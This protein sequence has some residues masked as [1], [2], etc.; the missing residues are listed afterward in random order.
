M[1]R[2]YR[3]ILMKNILGCSRQ[4]VIRTYDMKGSKYARQVIKKNI[5]KYDLEK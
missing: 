5:E 4:Q 2:T 3:F 1:Q